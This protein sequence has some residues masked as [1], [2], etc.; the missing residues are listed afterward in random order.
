MSEQ[1]PVG[2]RF[3]ISGR[4]QGV[5]YRDATRRQ[6][7]TLALQGNV[8]NLPDG[9]VEVLAWGPP[10]ALAQ[11]ESWLWRGPIFARVDAVE[12]FDNDLPS[13]P[14]AGFVIGYAERG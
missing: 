8:R 3:L 11:L 5:G 4:V 10:S 13:D 12:C 1:P 7:R 6:A 14:G 2:R 9:R